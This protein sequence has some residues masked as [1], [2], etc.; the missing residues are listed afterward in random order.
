MWRHLFVVRRNNMLEVW[1]DGDHLCRKGETPANCDLPVNTIA[2][3][4]HIRIGKR[5][6]DATRE[7]ETVILV[8]IF[9]LKRSDKTT[10]I[11]G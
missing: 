3:R 7:S 8:N 10:Q 6:I 9:Q 11:M 4:G 2:P 5:P 1:L